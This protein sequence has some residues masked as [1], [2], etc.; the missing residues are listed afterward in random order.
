MLLTDH[1]GQVS[2][3]RPGVLVEGK[4][5]DWRRVIPDFERLTPGN[6]APYN[7]RYLSNVLDVFA[8]G[9]R[10]F[11]V[12]PRPFQVDQYSAIVWC[13]PR[14]E[15]ALL[16]IMP[17]RDDPTDGK[18]PDLFTK[19]WN[20]NARRARQPAEA[21]AE[22]PVAVPAERGAAAQGSEA[23]AGGQRAA[24]GEEQASAPPASPDTT[25]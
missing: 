16:I 5:P 17:M 18:L 12:F 13:I 9:K 1:L 7:H 22:K 19:N 15:N 14:H 21:K 11:G 10:G 2:Y 4:F 23:Q 25:G 3:V 6:R 24:G 8:G 20:P